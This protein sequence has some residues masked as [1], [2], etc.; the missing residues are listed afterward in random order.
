VK[1]AS[2]SEQPLTE[3]LRSGFQPTETGKYGS[4]LQRRLLFLPFLVGNYSGF[5]HLPKKKYFFF[6]RKNKKIIKIKNCS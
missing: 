3:R 6:F 2:F 4:V 1:E 5:W